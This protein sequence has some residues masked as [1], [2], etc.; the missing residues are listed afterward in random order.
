MSRDGF[1]ARAQGQHASRIMVARAL[2][3]CS[4][5]L[6]SLNAHN[7]IGLAQVLSVEYAWSFRAATVSTYA[8]KFCLLRAEYFARSPYSADSALVKWTLSEIELLSLIW[9]LKRFA[10]ATY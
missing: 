6:S 10:I 9:S 7:Y 8:V 4:A 2:A 5:G 3:T 1:K